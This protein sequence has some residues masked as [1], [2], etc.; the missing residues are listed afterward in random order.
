MEVRILPKTVCCEKGEVKMST[1]YTPTP[2]RRSWADV[3]AENGSFTSSTIFRSE[4]DPFDPGLI[5][6]EQ[7]GNA[8]LTVAAVNSYANHCGERA[9]ECAEED[10]LGEC[11]KQI[12]DI[13]THIERAGSEYIED[14]SQ[15]HIELRTVLAKAGRKP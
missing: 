5:S 8:A 3:F 12:E 9:V 14:D 10:L 2:W 1:K 4:R 11:L 6:T 13:V 15:T 7:L